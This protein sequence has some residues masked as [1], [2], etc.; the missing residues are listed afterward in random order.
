MRK[1]TLLK[2]ASPFFYTGNRTGCLLLHG[3]TGS[4]F[5]MRWLGQHLNALGYTVYG[6]RLPGHGT[7]PH[8]LQRVSWR[9]WYF[10]ALD[11]YHLLRERCDRVFVMGLSMGGALT[12]LLASNEAVDGLIAFSTPY[13]LQ[14]Q[15]KRP[16]RA[17]FPLLPSIMWALPTIAKSGTPERVNSFEQYVREEAHHRGE[18]FSGR[19]NYGTW[20]TAA[21]WELHKLLREMRSSLDRIT[22][23]AL[24][25]YSKSDHT[26]TLP[27]SQHI[28]DTLGTERK[29]LVLLEDSNH[30]VTIHT[31]HRLVFDTVSSFIEENR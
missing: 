21:V 17:L 4:P 15:V 14:S 19:G 29:S 2:G 7:D 16:M 11:G 27:N 9:E 18:E 25:I 22:A 20:V 31:E 5:E 3:L 30:N 24:L 26:V 10:C 23:P 1:I 8:D 13:D 12:L 28:Y 6:P